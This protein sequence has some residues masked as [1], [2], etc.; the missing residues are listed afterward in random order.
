MAIITS[1]NIE[2]FMYEKRL[3]QLDNPDEPMP[4]TRMT[5]LRDAYYKKYHNKPIKGE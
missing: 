3:K 5:R 1:I 2:I 4:S